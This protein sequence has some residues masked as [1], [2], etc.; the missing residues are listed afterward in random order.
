MGRYQQATTRQLDLDSGEESADFTPAAGLAHRVS[1]SVTLCVL[2]G[3]HPANLGLTRQHA[4]E[5]L[6][7]RCHHAVIQH[8]KMLRVDRSTVDQAVS[9][10]PQLARTHH[11]FGD[12]GLIIRSGQSLTAAA[13]HAALDHRRRRAQVIARQ[14]LIS[15]DCV[16]EVATIE[17]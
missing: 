6:C 9:T 17:A 1:R 16:G 14:A 13:R 7:L 2:C 5:K 10:F 12:V 15:L 11:L 8:L 3:R 4:P